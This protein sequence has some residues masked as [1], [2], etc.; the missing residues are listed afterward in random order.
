MTATEA[1]ESITKGGA[2]D[3]ALAVAVLDR[4]P[5]WWLSK[6]KDELDLIRIAEVYPKL[7][8]LIPDEITSQFE[9]GTSET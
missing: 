1:Y 7:R 6:K 3:F 8:A 5:P 2:S 4:N 9:E